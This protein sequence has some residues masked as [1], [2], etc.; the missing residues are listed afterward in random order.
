MNPYGN[1]KYAKFKRLST[2][3]MHLANHSLRLSSKFITK[4]CGSLLSKFKTSR[5]KN[6]PAMKIFPEPSKMSSVRAVRALNSTDFTLS[7]KQ[8]RNAVAFNIPVGNKK[9]CPPARV[10]RRLRKQKVAPERTLGDAKEKLRAAEERKLRELERI[11]EYA[12]MS[13]PVVNVSHPAETFAQ[14]TAA[15]I[16]AK[17]ATAENRRNEEIKKKKQAG[18]IASR[19]RSRIVAD[20]QNKLLELDTYQASDDDKSLGDNPDNANVHGWEDFIPD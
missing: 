8:T 18:I 17:Q 19:N 11:Q 20:K 6:D 14:A 16:A 1:N 13:W 3:F 5:N 15:K 9:V 12:R 4:M 10:S 2:Q 7:L